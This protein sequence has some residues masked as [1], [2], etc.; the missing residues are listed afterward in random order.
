MGIHELAKIF[1]LRQEN[2]ILPVGHIHH[3]RII[4]TG[5]KLCYREYVMA[6]GAKRSHHGEVA[7]LV[8]KEFHRL[9][10]G[11]PTGGS[12]NQHRL[13]VGHGVCC[14]ANSGVNIGFGQAGIGIEQIRFRRTFSK[15]L[16]NQ[17]NRNARTTDDGFAHHHFRIHLNTM[18]RHGLSVSVWGEYSRL[19]G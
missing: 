2:P 15:L 19:T 6:C 14:I 7:T 17:L 13:L 5:R 18:R 10:L 9:S 4:G 8:G 1:I 11:S 3:N 12:F 16:E